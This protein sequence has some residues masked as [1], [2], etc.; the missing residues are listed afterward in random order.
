MCNES[1]MK[2]EGSRFYG[3]EISA[4]NREESA[5][6]NNNIKCDRQNP[7]VDMHQNKKVITQNP[8]HLY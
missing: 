7:E 1:D 2:S 8:I 4:Y 3:Y 6:N 5:I